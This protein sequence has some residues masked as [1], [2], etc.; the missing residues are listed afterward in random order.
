MSESVGTI[1]VEITVDGQKFQSELQKVEQTAKTSG[2]S[3]SKGLTGGLGTAITAVSTAYLAASQLINQVTG[4]IKSAMEEIAHGAALDRI[5]TQFNNFASSVGASGDSILADLNRVTGGIVENSVLM[6]K[7]TTAMF[8]GL[9]TT[10][11]T[12]V[13]TIA[14]G[15]ARATGQSIEGSMDQIARAI[16]TGMMR[17]LMRAGLI[18]K[19]ESQTITK[20][21]G[22]TGDKMTV[23]QYL[24]AKNAAQLE[25]LG[26]NAVDTK[27]IFDQLNNGNI[28]FFCDSFLKSNN[29]FILKISGIW[30]THTNYGLTYKFT[31]INL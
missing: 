23:L 9:N 2:D 30:E 8:K 18:T 21:L 10:E 5:E 29:S 4:A 3:I 15:V 22:M 19:E 16:E 11:L 31:K 1:F 14:A 13:M 25:K 6:Q 7:A 28:K 24:E 20:Y 12:S 17:P 26:G 27:Q